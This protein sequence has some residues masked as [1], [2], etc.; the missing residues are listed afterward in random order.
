[1]LL[2]WGASRTYGIFFTPLQNEFGWS[3]ATISGAYTLSS[4]LVGIASIFIGRLTDHFGPRVILFSCG[5]FLGLGYLLMSLIF[6][7]WHVYLYYGLIIAIGMSGAFFGPN[8]PVSRSKLATI[9]SLSSEYVR[10]N[11]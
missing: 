11:C 5:I 6:E 1:M 4:V 8:W 3:R 9:L 7:V 2:A 10:V